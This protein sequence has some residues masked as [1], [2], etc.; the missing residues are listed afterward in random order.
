MQFTFKYLP[1]ISFIFLT[2]FSLTEGKKIDIVFIG[3][4][5]TKGSAL[6]DPSTEA[7]PLF[8]EQM[9]KANNHVASVRVAN[10]GFS[11]HTTCD[12]LPAAATDFPK[13][14]EAANAFAQDKEA[15][16]IFSIMLGTNDS[17]VSGTNGSPVSPA[18]YRRNLKT[19][20]DA[21]LDRFPGA[22][23]VLQYPT[24]YSPNTHN[25]ATYLQEGL[26][27]LGSYYPQIDSLIQEYKITHPHQVF[28]GDRSAFRIFKKGY[29]TLLKPEQGKDGVFYLHP[30][31]EGSKE[32]AKIWTKGILKTILP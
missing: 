27:R 21:L 19:I 6:A 13:V 11:G 1:L 10:R 8:V 20:M 26:E 16:L 14:L 24:W 31:T 18:D 29:R 9:L 30:N 23:F 25:G 17:A 22:K 28:A 3:D 12:F 7:T 4:S 2:S 15:A 5:I 32:L